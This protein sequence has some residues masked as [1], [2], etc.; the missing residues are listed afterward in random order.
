MD[1]KNHLELE[2]LLIKAATRRRKLIPLW[3][4]IFI[5]IFMIFGAF[6]PLIFL[7][8][9]FVNNRNDGSFTAEIYGL[10]TH[11]AFSK[12]GLFIGFLF[13]FKGIAAWSLWN[14]KR[15]A[16]IVA[17]LDAIIG[18]IVCFY[19]MLYPE[20]SSDLDFRF[21]VILLIPYLIWLFQTKKTW[22]DCEA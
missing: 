10:K 8:E 5:W 1:E 17:I 12:I 19:V 15:S 4:K 11:E 16:V 9:L 20:N 3:I 13:L 2:P 22:E 21:E 6:I 14:E 18:I 7:I